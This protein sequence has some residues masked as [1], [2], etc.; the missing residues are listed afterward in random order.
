M[1]GKEQLLSL[2]FSTGVSLPRHPPQ[3]TIG[4]TR[5]P[6]SL[7]AFRVSHRRLLRCILA[8]FHIVSAA[9]AVVA[10]VAS[11]AAAVVVATSV[12]AEACARARRGVEVALGVV[13]LY[14]QFVSAQ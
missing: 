12:A 8:A 4:N 13:D 1:N 2:D 14:A 9:F 11:A 3:L 5:K 7:S 6:R 10:V